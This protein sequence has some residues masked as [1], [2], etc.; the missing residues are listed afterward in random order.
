MPAFA[1]F[2]QHDEKCLFLDRGPYT[3]FVTRFCASWGWTI[4]RDGQCLAGR[5]DWNL[6]AHEA[7]DQSFKALGE[8]IPL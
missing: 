5:K 3:V 2:T 6:G 7:C 8:F 4:W 1:L